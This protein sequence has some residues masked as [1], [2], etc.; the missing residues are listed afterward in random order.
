MPLSS[1][2]L[3]EALF[4]AFSILDKL[5]LIRQGIVTLV[6]IMYNRILRSTNLA[7]RMILGLVYSVAILVYHSRQPMEVLGIHLHFLPLS[8]YPCSLPYSDSQYDDSLNRLLDNF[9]AKLVVLPVLL[10]KHR[11]VHQLT[12]QHPLFLY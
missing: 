2:V 4:A 9:Q 1:A 7:Y 10:A 11:I 6:A 12:G 3:V 8:H 5:S